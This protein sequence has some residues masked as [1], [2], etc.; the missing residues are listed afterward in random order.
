MLG[1]PG[2]MDIPFLYIAATQNFD[3]T[4]SEKENLGNY[5]KNG[6]FLVIENANP[7]TEPG[8]GGAPLKQMIRDSIHNAI[9]KPIPNDHRLYHAFFDFFDGPPLGAELS[10]TSLGMSRSIPYLE[11]VW[12]EDRLAVIFSG[13]GYIINWTEM[14]NNEPQLKMGVN[15]VV[16]SLIQEGGMAIRQ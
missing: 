13:K 5:L 9:F 12:I 14:E 3:L 10:A 8:L 6:G 11:G 2:I 7:L 1:S 15:M 16:F 4:D